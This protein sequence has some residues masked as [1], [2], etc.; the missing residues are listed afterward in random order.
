MSLQTQQ[1]FFFVWILFTYSHGGAVLKE[2]HSAYYGYYDY[3]FTMV[4]IKEGSLYN[5][6]C[7]S[8][9]L[10]LNF[11]HANNRLLPFIVLLN[12]YY[13]LMFNRNMFIYHCH[14]KAYWKNVRL[15]NSEGTG[16]PPIHKWHLLMLIS[17]NQTIGLTNHNSP[18][19]NSDKE[20]FDIQKKKSLLTIPNRYFHIFQLQNETLVMIIII[21][22]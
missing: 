12:L 5:G 8:P 21:L 10:Y 18:C 4:I 19:T 7:P 17:E 22:S 3:S 15:N 6:T 20:Y 16:N 11:N 2:K 1:A 13:L 14:Q 9:D